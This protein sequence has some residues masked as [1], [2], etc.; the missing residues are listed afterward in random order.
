M[1]VF[2]SESVA[3]GLIL[4]ARKPFQISENDI[5]R[6]KKATLKAFSA[7]ENGHF[8]TKKGLFSTKIGSF[9]TKIGLSR[10]IENETYF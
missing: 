5:I 8:S 1:A 4:V 7:T 9:V 6:Q 10:S 3:N 2:S